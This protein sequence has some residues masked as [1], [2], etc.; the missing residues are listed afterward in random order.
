MRA[1]SQALMAFLD[2]LRSQRDSLALVADCYTFI[3]Q[4]GLILTYTS[5]DVPIALNGAI[6]A[7]N[8]VLVDGL[9]FKCEV[10]LG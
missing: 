2:G 1:T 9:T 7:A 6:F 3:L 8:S 4:T 10:G 5:A